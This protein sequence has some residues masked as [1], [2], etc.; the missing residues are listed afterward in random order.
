MGA[1]MGFVDDFAKIHA[2]NS[3]GIPGRMKL[4]IQLLLTIG[5]TIAIR[6]QP[7]F[8][9]KYCTLPIPFSNCIWTITSLGIFIIFLFLVLGGSSN[10]VNL[11]DGLDGLVTKCSI[12]VLLF[13][14]MATI[15]TGS[16]TLSAF[17]HLPHISGNGELAVICMAILGTLVIF[18]WHNGY[19]ATIFMGDTGSLSL[20]M[21][22]GMVG[23]LS[24]LP[25]HFAIAGGIFVLEALSDIIQVLSFK[26]LNGRRIFKMAP[27]H[28]HFELSGLHEVKITERFGILSW[29]FSLFGIMGFGQF[30]H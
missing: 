7:D 24:G 18:Q 21:L 5:I 13:L 29:L 12:P 6:Y 30:F 2:K 8:Y 11:T 10:A 26:Y 20:G 14:A 27:I 22:M 28:H 3:R 19:P 16:V 15:S 1:M 23:F 17:L 4:L 9:A 25:F